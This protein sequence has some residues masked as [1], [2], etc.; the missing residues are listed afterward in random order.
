MPK[1]L[2]Y[3]VRPDGVEPS[4]YNEV[5]RTKFATFSTSRSERRR[6]IV[7]RSVEDRRNAARKCNEGARAELP[8]YQHALTTDGLD[9]PPGMFP[10]ARVFGYAILVAIIGTA[11]V[12]ILPGLLLLWWLGR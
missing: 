11:A 7:P 2:S 9:I 5:D 6:E 4:T 10:T 8:G 3:N 1:S 12:L